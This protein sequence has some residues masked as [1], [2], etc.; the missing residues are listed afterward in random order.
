MEP[1]VVLIEAQNLSHL[2][3]RIAARSGICH[4]EAGGNTE[5]REKDVPRRLAQVAV[6]IEGKSGIAFNQRIGLCW[7]GASSDSEAE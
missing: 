5:G 1:E 4:G 7:L 2:H 3:F 6:E